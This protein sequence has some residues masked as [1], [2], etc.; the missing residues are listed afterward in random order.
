[1]L[2]DAQAAACACGMLAVFKQYEL[3]HFHAANER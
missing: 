2:G 3:E 1:M